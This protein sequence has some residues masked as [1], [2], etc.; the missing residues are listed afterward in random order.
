MSRSNTS[1]LKPLKLAKHIER[2]RWRLG[3]L[4]ARLWQTSDIVCASCS[5]PWRIDEALRK[6]CYHRGGKESERG[7]D[8]VSASPLQ[9]P[10]LLREPSISAGH[11]ARTLHTF[12]FAK[13]PER[14]GGGQKENG[15]SKYSNKADEEEGG[16]LG[17][18]YIS[19]NKRSFSCV[20]KWWEGWFKKKTHST[21]KHT[22]TRIHTHRWSFYTA[23]AVCRLTTILLPAVLTAKQSTEAHWALSCMTR[24]SIIMHTTASHNTTVT[25]IPGPAHP[26]A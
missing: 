12:R 5:A 6:W 10:G 4:G 8:G 19:D 13:W 16:L 18:I 3:A 25:A 26:P 7:Q 22:H 2:S 20:S 24:W 15:Q 23:L 21:L 1:V 17:H 11:R 9:N 14:K